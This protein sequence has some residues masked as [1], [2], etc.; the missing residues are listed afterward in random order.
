MKSDVDTGA[1]VYEGAVTHRR[2]KPVSHHLRYRVF[3]FLLDLDALD[4][5]A[6][7]LRWFSR[8][9]FN[10]F[11]FHDRD[12]GD[13]K[14]DDLAGYIRAA[15][16]G[17]GVDGGGRILA[18]CYPRMLGY[19]FN[20]LTVYYCHD[21]DNQLAAIIYEVSNTFGGRHSY[22]IPADGASDRIEQSADKRFHVSP[23]IDMDMRYAFSLTRPGDDISVSIQTSDEEGPLLN[24]AFKGDASI[25]SDKKLSSLFARYPLMTMKVIAGIHWE[26]LKLA[27]KGL[28]L[29]AGAPT[30]KAPITVVR[31]NASNIDAA[32]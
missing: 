23:F 19:A 26:A 2:F 29:R 31:A 5:A 20:P 21:G 3:S 10:L 25:L 15:L 17:A 32:A 14:S 6:E 13:G 1:M 28:R 4:R 30:P 9:R 18:L 12:H 11:S 22:L 27:L 24:A 8:N 7:N 16:T